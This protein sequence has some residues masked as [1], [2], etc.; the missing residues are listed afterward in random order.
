[1]SRGLVPI[2]A[3]AV[4]LL[5]NSTANCADLPNPNLTPGE[6]MKTVVTEKA[7]ECLSDLMGENVQVGDPITLDMIVTHGYTKCVRDVSQKLKLQV[8]RAY[9]MSGPGEGYC[10]GPRKCEV[11]HLCSLEIGG[12]NTLANLW[13]QPYADNPRKLDP[14]D[15]WKADVKDQLENYLHNEIV[16]GRL[17][18]EEACSLI[19]KDWISLYRTKIGDPMTSYQRTIYPTSRN[20]Q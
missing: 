19:A 8:Y 17:T 9:G 3:I 13:P 14:D 7:A 12:A 1:M 15:P 10:S 2:L 18:P 11:D 4:L 6:L 20:Q 16:A 5:I